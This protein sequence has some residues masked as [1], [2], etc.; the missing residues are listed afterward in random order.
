ME[1]PIPLEQQSTLGAMINDYGFPIIAAV[2]MGYFIYFIWQWVTK[3]IDP[4]IGEA[5]GVLIGLID[6]IRMLDN[7]LI[8]LNQKLNVVLTLKEQQEINEDKIAELREIIKEA[9][10][11][12]DDNEKLH[13]LED[14]KKIYKEEQN[15]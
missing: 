8:R 4:V 13:S 5:Q 15:K 1:S 10:L 7:D 11:S 12:E 3:E 9:G 6:R 2:G 14:L